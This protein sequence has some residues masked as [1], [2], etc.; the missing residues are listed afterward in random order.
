M[1]V[2]NDSATCRHDIFATKDSC[3]A[4]EMGI[5]CQ[6]LN[7]TQSQSTPEGTWGVDSWLHAFLTSAL[8]GDGAS[9]P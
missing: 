6:A 7:V 4:E 1:N 8:D 3:A 5:F 9:P 2:A